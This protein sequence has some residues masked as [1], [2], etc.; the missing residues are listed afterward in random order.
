M[1]KFLVFLLIAMVSCNLSD[2]VH[3]FIEFIRSIEIPAWLIEKI[4]EAIIASGRPAAYYLCKKYMD[5]ATCDSFF[6]Y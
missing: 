1:K 4:K 6:G 3:D 2:A 5:A